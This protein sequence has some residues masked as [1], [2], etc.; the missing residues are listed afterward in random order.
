LTFAEKKSTISGLIKP[1]FEQVLSA[2]TANARGWRTFRVESRSSFDAF[3]SLALS[4]KRALTVW[5]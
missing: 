3:A 1:S 2:E 4:K 5:D